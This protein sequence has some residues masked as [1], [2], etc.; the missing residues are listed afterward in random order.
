M[1]HVWIKR[2][3]ELPLT[4][5]L[6]ARLGGDSQALCEALLNAITSYTSRW[7]HVDFR[8]VHPSIVLP[9]LGKM[10]YLRTISML[11]LKDIQPPFD[12]CPKLARIYWYFG[13]T[14][15]SVPLSWHQ[16]THLRLTRAIPTREMFFV[17]QSCSK[18]T[19]LEVELQ[20]DVHESLSCEMVIN[21]SLRELQLHVF[22]IHNPLLERLTLPAL[23]ELSFDF[24]PIPVPG[25]QEELLRF[26]SRSKC[27]L[28]RLVLEECGFDDV[29][30]FECLE[31]DS[32]SSLMD[33]RISNT[34]DTPMFTDAVLIPLTD[35]PSAEN[36][37]LLPKLTHL[38]LD[39]CLGGSPS[40][41]GTMILSRRIPFHKQDQLRR[42]DIQYTELDERDIHLLQLAESLG[43]EVTLDEAD[44]WS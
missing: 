18:L 26:F 41:L 3:G 33:L 4:L 17:I 8:Y 7:E 14:I 22:K 38:S 13:G 27:K 24:I 11:V 35:I 5:R 12:S 29:R 34:V 42:L 30:L 32:C 20:D 2:S 37:V 28:T 10:P 25:F 43:L 15:S 39:F 21:R 19:D 31:H 1:T 36:N 44:E 16:L 9:Q 6:Y 23:T 40:R